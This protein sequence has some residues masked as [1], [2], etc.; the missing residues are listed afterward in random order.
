VD[1]DAIT[2]LAEIFGA[3]G[4]IGAV[5]VA[6]FLQYFNIRRARPKLS[7]EFSDHLHDEDLALV[8]LA[9]PSLFLRLKVRAHAG[10]DVA[11][12]VQVLL[13]RL[14]RPTR[15]L[16][17]P[18][19]PS[20]NL[21]WADTPNEKLDIPP[22]IWR[23]FDFLNLWVEPPTAAGHCL[24]PMLYQYD[25]PW[26]PHPRHFLR[27]PGRYRMA[28]AVVADNTDSTFWQVDVDYAPGPVEEIADLCQ[29][30]RVVAVARTDGEPPRL[31]A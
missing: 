16:P 14:D 19:V 9:H 31:A 22:G 25:E 30:L 23:R 5:V 8:D 10:K 18:V 13:L 20:R 1:A 2:V 24:A 15:T 29:Q 6:L 12:N 11:R 3:V 17:P 4:T 7:L 27:D 28:L 21:K 26:P